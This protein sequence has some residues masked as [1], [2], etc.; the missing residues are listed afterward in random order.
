MAK[1]NQSIKALREAQHLILSASF[2]LVA[3]LIIVFIGWTIEGDA[4][5]LLVGFGGAFLLLSAVIYW[6]SIKD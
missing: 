5:Q 4:G 3:G 1:K 2:L 6:G